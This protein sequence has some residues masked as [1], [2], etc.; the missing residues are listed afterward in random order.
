MVWSTAGLFFV[1][2]LVAL[3]ST[4]LRI[5]D[6]NTFHER[7]VSESTKIYDKTGEVLLYDAHKD[8]QRTV[9]PITEISRY[10][11][12]AIVAIEDA[13]FYEHNGIQPTAIIRAVLVNLGAFEFAQGG[14]TITQQVVKNSILTQERTVTRKLKE[15]ILSLKLEKQ[16]SKEQILE[17]YLNEAPYG[18]SLYGAEEA[19]LAYFG[20]HAKDLTLAQS[21]Y[22][23]ALP[24]AP[25]YYSPYGNHRDKLDARKNLV[26]SK[27]NT[28]GFITKEDRVAAQ[29]ELV[30]F[31]PN[32]TG[33]I[34]APHFVFYVI[35]QLEKMYGNDA[36]EKGGLKVTT[37]L[38]Y[39]LQ[40]KAEGIMARHGEENEKKYS[41]KNAGFV[42]V[43]PK[44]GGII[45]MV[46]SRNYFDAENDGNFN[47]TTSP[48]RQ[49]GSSFKPFVYAAAFKKGYTPETVVFDL[50]T[51]FNTRCDA[52]GN[53][54]PGE[55]VKKS[56]CYMPEN[57]DNKYHGPMTF[58][59]ALAQSVNIASVK[60]L[61][62]AGLDDSLTTARDMGITSLTD[63]QR[64]GLTLV[65]GGGEVSLLEMVGAYGVFANDGL[66]NPTVAILK[67]EDSRGTTL[68]EH[69]ATERRVLTADVARQIGDILSD[70]DA[71]S[72]AFGDRSFLYFDGRDVAVKTGT[73]NDY[74]D[75]WIVGYTPSIAAGA[76]VGNN[77]N[78][79]MEKKVAGFIVAP[80]WNE[81]MRSALE[82]LPIETFKE[83]PRTPEELK[84][85][86][87]GKWLGGESVFIDKVSGKL[88]TDYTPVETRDE[89]FVTSV[90]DILY[91]VNKQDPRGAAASNPQADAQ[92]VLW[93]TPVRAW[94]A[95]QKII[96][97][98]REGLPT[99]YDD[100][101]TPELAPKVSLRGVDDMAEYQPDQKVTVTATV[102]GKHPISR[103]DFY[104]NDTHIGSQKASPAVI[105][106]IPGDKGS[107]I[108]KNTIKAVVYDTI[109]N[110]GEV[111]ISLHL[112]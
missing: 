34:N 90:H 45:V 32:A 67:I 19:S 37:T 103:V 76:W 39:E 36:V 46:G 62:L 18:G 77:D 12:N 105:S 7:R 111:E 57:Y 42:A 106:F 82:K 102:T 51:Q 87:R 28:L 41:A 2:G 30:F 109:Y 15:L 100:V 110:R 10:L 43:N 80:L 79:P 22:L 20:V 5:P 89:R 68:Y 84:P 86:L 17:I 1:G 91:W 44:S 54:L 6:L 81:F 27:M 16:M 29:K 55:T 21:A 78:T 71:R 75:A 56:S 112:K 58:R 31:K 8:V 4:T 73:T 23:A 94:V 93:E 88:A 72:P 96:E 63:K 59:E 69:T 99:L 95:A 13:E 60:V 53:P 85:V 92:F 24:Q 3:W 108:G 83:P 107:I 70:N 97:S 25:T 101:H 50:P 26:L 47:V 48:N 66:R 61:Y 74:R 35:E 64:Y 104:F 33:S 9:V 14:S 52:Y 11:K 40:L 49:P 98:S 38:D 65:L